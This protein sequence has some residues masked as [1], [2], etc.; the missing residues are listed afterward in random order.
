MDLE[1]DE[2]IKKAIWLSLQTDNPSEAGPSRVRY[3]TDSPI[4]TDIFSKLSNY[5]SN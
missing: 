4:E 2:N 5:T 1:K 3:D